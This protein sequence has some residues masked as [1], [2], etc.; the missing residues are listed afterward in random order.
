MEPMSAARKV[1]L[2]LLLALLA[3]TILYAVRDVT[4][5]RGR[6]EWSRTLQ[7]AFVIVTEPGVDRAA[8]SRVRAR[9]PALAA[10]LRDELRRYRPGAAA[11]FS[12]VAYGPDTVRQAVPEPPAD[13]IVPALKHAY[14]LRRFTSAIDEAL[15]VPTRGFDARLYLVVR[16][17]TEQAAVE[18]MSEHG[19]RVA[20]ALAELDQETVDTALIVAA[21]ELF[22]TVG[23]QD[24]YG[25][26][27]RALVPSGLAEPARIPRYPQ[28]SVE[29]MARNRPISATDEVRPVSLDELAVGETTAR[30]LGWLGSPDGSR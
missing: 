6:N 4:S 21:H 11:P 16:P 17:A 22:H 25:P 27:G 5:R 18:G 30:E 1:R 23:A 7:V 28:R 15:A 3:A 29:V 20:I 14:A 10:R 19:G 8:V 13:G 12:F 24:H 9:V 26:D 2:A